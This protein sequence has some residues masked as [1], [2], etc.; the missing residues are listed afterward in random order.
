VDRLQK[1]QRSFEEAPCLPANYLF[2]EL[3]FWI[4]PNPHDASEKEAKDKSVLDRALAR[5]E[6]SYF[7]TSSVVSSLICLP[8]A[9]GSL[10]T[11]TRPSLGNSFNLSVSDR[12]RASKPDRP[13]P[14]CFTK[15]LFD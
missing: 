10:M 4:I 14:S 8:S 1:F 9:L 13:R 2:R 11:S 15:L 7:G 6:V 5:F 3:P 12:H